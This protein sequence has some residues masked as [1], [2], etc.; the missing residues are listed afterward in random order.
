[1]PLSK[2]LIWIG[3]LVGSAS[4]GWVPTLWGAGFVSLSSVVGSF[5]GALLGLWAAVQLSRWL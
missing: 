3:V 5:V 2:T 1:M 4:G